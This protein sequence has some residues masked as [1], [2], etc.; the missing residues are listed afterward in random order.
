MRSGISGN[1]ERLDFDRERRAR[2]PVHHAMSGE[3]GDRALYPV[4]LFSSGTLRLEAVQLKSFGRTLTGGDNAMPGFRMDMIE[5]TDPEVVR[6]SGERFHPSSARRAIQTMKSPERSSS[7]AKVNWK[8]RTNTKSPITTC[9]SSVAI[10]DNG[11][12]LRAGLGRHGPRGRQGIAKPTGGAKRSAA[13]VEVAL[14]ETAQRGYG[15]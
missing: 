12:G 9:R 5:I 3:A 13:V 2:Q 14:S 8:P 15:F 10:G 11:L 1:Q 7:S 4:A 6:T